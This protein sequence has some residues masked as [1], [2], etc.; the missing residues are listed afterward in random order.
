VASL[1]AIARLLT[2]IH[3]ARQE[4]FRADCGLLPA[5]MSPEQNGRS[6]RWRCA[7][8]EI[9]LL[10]RVGRYCSGVFASVRI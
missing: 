3:I 4:N 5:R 10:P 6:T 9:T 1:K 7:R 8:S 2:V